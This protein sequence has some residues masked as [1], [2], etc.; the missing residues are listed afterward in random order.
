MELLYSWIIN[1]TNI[2]KSDNMNR[3][4]ENYIQKLYD[5]NDSQKKTIRVI[6]LLKCNIV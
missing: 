6:I 4:I 3:N 2:V 5:K 1:R